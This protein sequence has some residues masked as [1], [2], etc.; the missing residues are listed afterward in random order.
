MLYSRKLEWQREQFHIPSNVEAGKSEVF[1]V[2]E[3]DYL[4]MIDDVDLLLEEIFC[5]LLQAC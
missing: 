3:N 4:A 5:K 2:G 1:S